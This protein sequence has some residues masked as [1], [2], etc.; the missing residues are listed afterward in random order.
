MQFSD[1]V[2]GDF[3]QPG[4]P[5]ATKRLLEERKRQEEADKARRKRKKASTSLEPFVIED[6][7]LGVKINKTA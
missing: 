3:V 2:E 4:E 7:A 5:G 6:D 1:L